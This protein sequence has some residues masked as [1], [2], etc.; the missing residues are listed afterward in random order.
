MIRFIDNRKGFTLIEVM[1]AAAFLII[2]LGGLLATYIS[3][4]EL[5][6][7]SRNLTLAVN[8][9]RGKVEEIRDYSFNQI[10]SDYDNTTFTVNEMSTGN[11]RGVVYVDNTNPDLLQVIVSV[12][13][14]QRANRI[15]GEDLDLDGNL[16]TGE[17]TN[18]NNMIDSPAQLITL[19]TAR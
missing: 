7:T 9:A 13:W 12:C 19:I 16:D 14:R 18:F 11:S 1:L 3:C 5:I 15:I 17:D 6:S 2:V 4:F 8:A 10:Y